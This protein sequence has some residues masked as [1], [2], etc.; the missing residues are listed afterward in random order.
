MSISVIENNLTAII[1]STLLKITV[2]DA[3]SK[4]EYCNLFIDLISLYSRLQQLPNFFVKLLLAL[5]DTMKENSLGQCVS[6]GQVY[7][8]IL[9]AVTV[10]FHELPFGQIIELW[11][12]FSE[13][14][15][16]FIN[17]SQVFPPGKGAVLFLAQF[18]SSLLLHPKLFD[19]FV[20]SVMYSEFGN[21]IRYTRKE[22]K[23]NMHILYD[24]NKESFLNFMGQSE[25]IL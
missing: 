15:A 10:H 2:D 12:I 20:P 6:R 21:L 4:E 5:T 18:F 7:P 19:A 11:K 16:T 9:K 14:Y 13:T 24:E 23:K 25:N 1:K 17:M 3:I 8:E 22:L